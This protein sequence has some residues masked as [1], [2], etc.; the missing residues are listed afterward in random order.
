MRFLNLLLAFLRIGI[1]GDEPAP[2]APEK[3]DPAPDLE[4]D[5][6]APE[7]PPAKDNDDRPSA[8]EFAAAQA[9]AKSDRERAD[10]AERERDEARRQRPAFNQ[11]PEFAREEAKLRDE[12]TTD[13]E[14]WQIQANRE[15]RAGRSVSQAAL[16]EARDI[17]DRTSFRALEAKKPVLFKRYE[18]K[19]E[20]E[21]ARVRSQGGNAS[22]EAILKYLV[23]QDAMDDKFSR[24]KAAPKDDKA[25]D[26]KRGKLPGARS[27]V[28]GKTGMTEHQK[29]IARLENQPI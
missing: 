24:K 27:D 10:R 11:D 17:S 14:R 21:L 26:V 13:L 19:V 1:E 8:E 22:R 3:D 12:K 6:D 25:P 5:L 15:L 18:A 20:E 23:G 9:A 16:A 2:D 7:D 29:R 4:V 28:S